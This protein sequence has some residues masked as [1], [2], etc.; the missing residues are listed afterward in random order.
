V[1]K[2]F[3][4]ALACDSYCST[5]TVRSDRTVDLKRWWKLDDSLPDFRRLDDQTTTFTCSDD[6][7][8]GDTVIWRVNPWP[9]QGSAGVQSPQ[10]YLVRIPGL[11]HEEGT[12]ARFVTA[13][14]TCMAA[15]LDAVEGDFSNAVSA[16]LYGRITRLVGVVVAGARGSTTTGEQM[17]ALLPLFHAWAHRTGHDVV[18]MC[19]SDT[20]LYHAIQSA[21]SAVDAWPSLSD[22]L[23]QTAQDLANRAL[24]GQL[25]LFIGAGVAMGCGLPSWSELLQHLAVLARL[26]DAERAAFKC[27][28]VLDQATILE[29][30]L[31]PAGFRRAIAER[32]HEKTRVS[33]SLLHCLLASLCGESLQ[34]VTTNYDVKFEQALDDCAGQCGLPPLSILPFKPVDGSPRWLLKM[35][36]CVRKPESIVITRK[37]YLNYHNKCEAIGGVVQA[38][39][40]TKHVLFLGF[41]LT[42]PNF[43]KILHAVSETIG[44]DLKSHA[45]AII[46]QENPIM[47]V[48]PLRWHLLQQSSGKLRAGAVGGPDESH[49]RD[50]AV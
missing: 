32:L 21:R 15:F 10:P 8:V 47:Q 23:R 24:E 22:R 6:F 50:P 26:T 12:G 17:N 33:Y 45:T 42:D 39:L 40:I 43:H 38:M 44:A 29:K 1:S 9:P 25:A 48:S 5:C 35:H 37:D 34:A 11:A 28:D 18:I 36:G 49:R 46:L 16:P 7:L 3:V 30:R 2:G 4:S 13:V 14:K 31:T 20:V 27:C 19:G 41:S